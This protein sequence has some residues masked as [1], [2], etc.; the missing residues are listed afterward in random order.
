MGHEEAVRKGTRQTGDP[1]FLRL[2]RRFGQEALLGLGE[3]TV[4]EEDFAVVM[5]HGFTVVRP[6][7]EESSK[8]REDPPDCVDF[9][10]IE[11]RRKGWTRSMEVDLRPAGRCFV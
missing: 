2:V 7:E 5:T 8:C 10:S 6:H 1:S 3:N 9:Y 11:L 4:E